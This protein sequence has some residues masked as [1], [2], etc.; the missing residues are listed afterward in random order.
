MGLKRPCLSDWSHTGDHEK[1]DGG[2]WWQRNNVS[3][4]T[5]TLDWSLAPP[6]HPRSPTQPSGGDTSLPVTKTNHVYT[7]WI[8]R[9]F[10]NFVLYPAV[11]YVKIS[12]A[13]QTFRKTFSIVLCSMCI[14]CF[15][16]LTFQN[17]NLNGSCICPS[18]AS[19]I[20]LVT[21]VLRARLIEKNKPN[22]DWWEEIGSIFKHNRCFSS[23]K[24]LRAIHPSSRPVQSTPTSCSEA[25]KA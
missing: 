11:S 5:L 16:G 21:R 18:L 9:I 15:I 17:L 2:D 25:Q 1:A 12:V 14:T 3:P 22:K 24:S 13:A 23:H 8:W 19:F 20:I 4:V 10:F 7:K 6:P